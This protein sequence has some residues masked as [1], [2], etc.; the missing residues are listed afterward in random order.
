MENLSYTQSPL[1]LAS[2]FAYEGLPQGSD[3]P[4]ADEGTE[5]QRGDLQIQHLLEWNVQQCPW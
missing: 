1:D 2:R 4:F 3:E 5:G